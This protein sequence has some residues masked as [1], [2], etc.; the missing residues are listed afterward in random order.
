[1]YP[2]ENKRVFRD[3]SARWKLQSI[4]WHLREQLT[5]AAE[6]GG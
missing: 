2:A 4:V 3:A 6:L 1:M 5:G